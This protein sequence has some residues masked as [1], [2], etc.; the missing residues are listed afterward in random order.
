[1]RNTFTLI[2]LLVCVPISFSQEQIMGNNKDREE[3][4]FLCPYTS[5]QNVISNFGEPDAVVGSGLV[6][7]QYQLA[8]GRKVNL[9]FGGGDKLY[10]LTEIS[11]QGERR[12]IFNTGTGYG[13]NS[14]S[15]N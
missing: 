1:M 14:T 8:D 5:Y 9:N 10:I 15:C 4:L 12:V 6:I 13:L 3:L 2:L 7:I 11:I